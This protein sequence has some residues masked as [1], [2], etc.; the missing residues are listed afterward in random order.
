ME[1]RHVLALVELVELL[2]PKGH[3]SYND[4]VLLVLLHGDLLGRGG[5]LLKEVMML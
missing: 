3:L 5:P 2:V 4:L 1:R